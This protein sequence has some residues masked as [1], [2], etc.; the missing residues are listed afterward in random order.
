MD[1]FNHSCPFRVN[2]TSNAHRCECVA[3]PNV[4]KDSFFLITS[5]RSL[6]EF[7]SFVSAMR[8]LADDSEAEGEE[9]FEVEVV[10]D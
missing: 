7:D 4:C 3:C 10:R 9:T 2:Q 8:D 5:N 1:C 6:T